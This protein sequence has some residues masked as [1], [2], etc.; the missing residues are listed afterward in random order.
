MKCNHEY[1]QRERETECKDSRGKKGNERKEE[2]GTQAE[3][4]G[5]RIIVTPNINKQRY[6]DTVEG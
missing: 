2:N 6:R 4:R 5:K 3:E 1:K